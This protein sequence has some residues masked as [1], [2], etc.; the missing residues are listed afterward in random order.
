M[1]FIFQLISITA[2]IAGFLYVASLDTY[3]LEKPL[4]SL[5]KRLGFGYMVYHSCSQKYFYSV[6]KKSAMEWMQA[7]LSDTILFSNTSKEVLC[8]KFGK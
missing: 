8:I 2:A 1:L 3:Y 4:R 6:R 7:G 5:F